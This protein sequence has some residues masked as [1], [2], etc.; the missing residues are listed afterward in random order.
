MTE[1][2]I[3][4]PQALPVHRDQDDGSKLG[5]GDAFTGGMVIATWTEESGWG[6][7]EM[8]PRRPLMVDPAMVGLHYGQTVF[9]GLKAYRLPDGGIGVFR[10]DAYA[11]RMRR[12]AARFAMPEPPEELFVDAVT[13]VAVRDAEWLPDDPAAA[14]YLR[15]LLVATEPSLALRPAR[16][17]AFLVIAFVTGGFFSDEPTPITVKVERDFVRAVRGG[18]GAAKAAGNYAPT[19]LAQTAAAGEDAQQVVWLDGVERRYV[20]ELGGMNLFFVHRRGTDVVVSTPPLS[21]SILP[22]ITRD[23][24]IVLARDLGYE[25][26]ERAIDVAEWRAGAIDGT[27]TETFA[28]GTAATVTAVGTVIDG[29]E[30]WTIG[31]NEPGPVTLQLR[32]EL[33]RAWLGESGRGA[34]WVHVGAPAHWDE[35]FEA[36]LRE[37][38]RFVPAGQPIDPDLAFGALGVISVEVL[39]LLVDCEQEFGVT[40]PTEILENIIVATPASFW[41][42]I[43]RLPRPA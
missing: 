2:P 15:P 30:R 17:Y 32:Q 13:S 25:V 35:R 24:L 40:V 42:A 29:A 26:E 4:L 33:R 43:S 27:V 7:L 3:Q 21:D 14:L 31:S 1:H 9:E 6:P 36:I 22:G 18:T 20:E 5:F 34:E 39:S 16:T 37:Y 41:A 19:Y 8:S 28:C 10:P 23:S 11:R 38:C 12:S